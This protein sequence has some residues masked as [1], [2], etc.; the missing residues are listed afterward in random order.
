MKKAGFSY[1]LLPLLLLV[2]FKSPTV[3]ETITTGNATAKSTVETNVEGSS[4]VSTHI[5]TTVNGKT[6]VIDSNQ[7]GKIEVENINGE[8]TV[9]KSPDV[10]ITIEPNENSTHSPLITSK[11]M[12]KNFISNIFEGLRNFLKRIFHNL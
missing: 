11:P 5:E 8:V 1:F 9:N 3:A 6:T 12:H 10:S 7:P 2:L 4:N